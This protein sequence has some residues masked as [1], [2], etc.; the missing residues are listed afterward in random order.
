[1]VDNQQQAPTHAPAQA[2]PHNS[3]ELNLV[4]RTVL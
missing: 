1:M 3:N 4:S 2:Q